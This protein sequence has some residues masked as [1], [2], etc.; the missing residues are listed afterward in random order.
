MYLLVLVY[1]CMACMY[2]CMYGMYV[3][4]Y[5]CTCIYVCMYVSIYVL[6]SVCVSMYVCMYICM[7]R[8]LQAVARDQILPGLGP[9]AM[10]RMM[11]DEPVAATLFSWACAQVGR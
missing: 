2:V 10:G 7:Y 4:M 8:I 5:L 11:D 1:L 3:C 6:V 9:F